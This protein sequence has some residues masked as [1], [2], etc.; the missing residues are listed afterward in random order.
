MLT[1]AGPLL[2]I[3]DRGDTHHAACMAAA[4]TL[5]RT[6]LLT[7]WPCFTEAMYLLGRSGGYLLQAGLWNLRNAGR[8]V[9]HDLTDAEIDRAASLMHRYQDTPMD[10]GDAS[11]VAVAE[12]GSHR[13]VFTLDRHFWIYRLADGSALE[14]IPARP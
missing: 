1:D 12:S 7:T 14:P 4:R 5:G 10:F 3:L 6:P 13:Q 8:L 9:L 2:A 11:L